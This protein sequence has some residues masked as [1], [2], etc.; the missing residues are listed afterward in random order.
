MRGSDRFYLCH[1]D[2][3]GSDAYYLTVVPPEVAS[4]NRLI[5]EAIVGRFTMAPGAPQ[6]LLADSFVPN[7]AFARILHHVVA[8][9]APDLPALRTEAARLGTGSVF[10]V[11]LR[12]ETPEGPVPPEDVLGYFVVAA[13]QVVAG[14]Y[15]DNPEH[16]LFTNRGPVRL[17]AELHRQLV[18]ELVARTRR[19]D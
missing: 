10:V 4:E 16:R 17:E 8:R 19:A 1:V 2:E 13:G 5:R 9:H 15:H 18:A 6:T 11:D 7:E 3:E 12:T 14:S